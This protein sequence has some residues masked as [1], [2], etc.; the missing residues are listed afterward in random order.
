MQL[1]DGQS[2]EWWMEQTQGWIR[3]RSDG[4]SCFGVLDIQ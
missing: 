1:L 2:V 3:Q 4:D